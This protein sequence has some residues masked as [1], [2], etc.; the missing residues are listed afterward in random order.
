MSSSVTE[1]KNRGPAVVF[2][3]SVSSMLMRR[4]P[5][6]V[7]PD[8][9][10]AQNPFQQ[11]LRLGCQDFSRLA[12]LPVPFPPPMRSFAVKNLSRLSSLGTSLVS[13]VS[14]CSAIVQFCLPSCLTRCTF[15]FVV[16]CCGRI[17][18]SVSSSVVPDGET[19]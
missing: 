11:G 3:S 12:F 14:S 4:V 19:F 18:M 9:S 17:Q 1:E 8:R 7:R 16:K 15:Y 5:S 13:R 2:I 10:V 6:V